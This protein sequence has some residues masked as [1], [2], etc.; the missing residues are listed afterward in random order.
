M[1]ERIKEHP[2]CLYF[3]FIGFITVLLLLCVTK[4]SLFRAEKYGIALSIIAVLAT[5]ILQPTLQ[6]IC[7]LGI[8]Q[9]D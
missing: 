8:V 4:Y 5:I 3:G 1:F 7:K 6:L 9:D 2:A